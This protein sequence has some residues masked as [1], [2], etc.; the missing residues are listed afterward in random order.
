MDVQSAA[1]A[2]RI[3]LKALAGLAGFAAALIAGIPVLGAVVF[4]VRARTVSEGEGFIPV[5]DESDLEEGR[6]IKAAVRTTRRD[7]WTEMKGVELAAVWIQKKRDGSIAVLSSICPHL[8]C[9][10]DYLPEG[11]SFNCPCHGSAF[12]RDGRVLT[13]PSP[14]AL[15]PLDARVENGKVLVKFERF[16]PGVPDRRKA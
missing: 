1:P 11:D 10:V 9:C 16:T 7:A 14:R 13:G 2:R 5:A 15:D 8:G 6:P 3:F 4:P 12:A